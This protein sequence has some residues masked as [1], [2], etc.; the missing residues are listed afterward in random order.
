MCVEQEA[1]RMQAKKKEINK[2]TEFHP[3][4]MMMKT[5]MWLSRFVLVITYLSNLRWWFCSLDVWFSW[6]LNNLISKRRFLNWLGWERC[7][8]IKILWL[9]IWHALR[10]WKNI[11]FP[12]AKTTIFILHKEIN[13]LHFKTPHSSDSQIAALRE[14]LVFL[15]NILIC[16]QP[17]LSLSNT[18]EP[19]HSPYFFS[20]CSFSFKVG[21]KYFFTANSGTQ[22][23]Q[24]IKIG[25][26]KVFRTSGV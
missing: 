21:S 23:V 12:L 8:L 26:H 14:L 9:C 20:S 22:R 2:V 7:C 24:I 18:S 13:I 10:S 15:L 16:H 6:Y 11:S 5:L 25:F 1:L 3:I 17:Y 19:S 4:Y